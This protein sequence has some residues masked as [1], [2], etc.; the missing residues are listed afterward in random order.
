MKLYLSSYRLGNKKELLKKL[1]SN[2]TRI[3]LIT[4]ALDGV[5]NDIEKEKIIQRTI[6]DLITVGLDPCLFDLQD[7]FGAKNQL[8]KD[9]SV[10]RNIFV[11]GGN[12]F[13]LRKAYMQSGFDEYLLDN[14]DNE[15]LLYAGYSAG[16]CV[17]GPT[18]K[19]LHFVDDAYKKVNSYPDKIVWNGLGLLDYCIAP[20]YK[21]NHPESELVE[22]TV[23]YYIKNEMK[24]KTL[25]DGDV[26]I[27]DQ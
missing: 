3:A 17:L 21:S 11:T 24:Y 18:L 7:Y 22:R 20:H 13:L 15:S 27:K 10:Y 5:K 26:I 4:N 14:I 9:I 1:A 25:Q 23:E 19:G 8:K 16:I 6:K 2:F 12:V